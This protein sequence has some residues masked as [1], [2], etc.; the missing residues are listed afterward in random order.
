MVMRARHSFMN[1]KHCRQ[2][3]ITSHSTRIASDAEEAEAASLQLPCKGSGGQACKVGKA[4]KTSWSAVFRI[5]L[6]SCLNIE[7]GQSYLAIASLW[8]PRPQAFTHAISL[9]NDGKKLYLPR[10]CARKALSGHWSRYFLE[11]SPD[12][13]WFL[14]LQKWN[15]EFIPKNWSHIRLKKTWYLEALYLP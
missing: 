11:A 15:F 9:F 7:S 6:W 13:D 4:G 2:G 14:I 1:R 10:P 12:T 3:Q 5:W 8:F